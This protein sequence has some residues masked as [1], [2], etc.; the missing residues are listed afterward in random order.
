MIG[1]I[2]MGDKIYHSFTDLEVWQLA[3]ELRLKVYLL[4]KYLP[5]FISNQIT[6]SSASIGAN[7]AEGY[8]RF[9]FQENIQYCRQA[10]G[11]LEET[12]DHLL[13]I[14]DAQMINKISSIDHLI[15]ICELLLPKLNG[16]ILY[17]KHQKNN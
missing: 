7:I 2:Y 11:S 14:K 15:K 17:L 8:G 5:K 9:H 13:F 1:V 12:K 6:R 4:S 10:R 16:Y 3:H